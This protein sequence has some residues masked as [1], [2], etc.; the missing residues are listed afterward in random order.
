MEFKTQGVCSRMIHFEIDDNKLKNVS[1][2]G[3][4]PGNLK[5]ISSLVEGMEAKDAIERLSGITCGNKTTSCPD[6]LAK[7]L[8]IE[9][10]AL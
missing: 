4:C 1:F 9:I 6:Q 2:D 8:A 3:G 5:A 10:Q 7:A